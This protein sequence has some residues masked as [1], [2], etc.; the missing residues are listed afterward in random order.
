MPD[1]VVFLFFGEVPIA[2]GERDKSSLATS[3]TL[4]A[5][6][7]CMQPHSAC[8]AASH[9]TSA[10]YTS[11]P[12]HICVEHAFLM[13]SVLECITQCLVCIENA[14]ELASEADAMSKQAIAPVTA[15]SAPH[16]RLLH[17]AQ[18]MS[19]WHHAYMLWPDSCCPH[20]CCL[21]S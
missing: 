8:S 13:H 9:N 5:S 19:S 7:D 20:T 4:T 21:Q 11:G 14:S 16:A 17:L 3:A 2:C 12:H 18:H 6:C 10:S 1:G 15:V